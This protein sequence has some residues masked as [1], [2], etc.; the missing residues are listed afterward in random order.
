M[1]W[2]VY[3]PGHTQ[4]QGWRWSAEWGEA[5]ATC[6]MMV[7]ERRQMREWLSTLSGVSIREA[8]FEALHHF[9]KSLEPRVGL[10]TALTFPLLPPPQKNRVPPSDSSPET[11][12]PGGIS[13]L[14]RTC[15]V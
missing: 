8:A 6:D 10:R 7:R 4:W 11:A 9:F 1:I 13:I 3:G 12:T 14:S 15:P 5:E 2:L